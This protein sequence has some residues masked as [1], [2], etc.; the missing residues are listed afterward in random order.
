M[1]Q[2][3][4]RDAL[5]LARRAHQ[6]RPSPDALALS[7]EIEEK[8]LV[9]LRKELLGGKKVPK[10]RIDGPAM[11]AMSLSAPERYLLSRMDGK[12]TLSAIV[13]VSPLRELDA[14]ACVQ[15]FVEKGF[16]RLDAA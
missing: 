13:S 12:R 16:I 10:V 9:S 4:L 1:A 14:L 15:L 6:V 7:R 3:N 5:A 11:R 2:A 8:W